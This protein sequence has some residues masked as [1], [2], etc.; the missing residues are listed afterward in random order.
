MS[1]VVAC[2][3]LCFVAALIA[4]DTPATEP[5]ISARISSCPPVAFLKREAHARK[6]TNA[7]MLGQ[8]TKAGSAICIYDPAHPGREAQTIFDTQKGFIFDMS[9]SYDGRMLLF[10]LMDSTR[11]DADGKGSFHIWEIDI[12]GSG[13]RQLTSGPYHDASAAYLPDG[14][15]VFC[16]TRV[17]SFSL[18]QDFLAAAMYTMDGDGSNLRRLE[19]NTL[20]DVTPWVMRDGSILFTRWEYQ[21]KN[22]F[23]VQG[24]WTINPDGTRVQLFYGNTL[25]IP[26]AIYGAKQIPG[27]HKVVCVMAAHHKLP[28]GAIGII[29]RRLGLE[30]PEAMI[31]ITPEVPYQPRIGEA[32]DHKQNQSWGPGDV[33]YP[34]SYTD[35]YPIAE[36]L[37]LVS[38]GGPAE[39]GP[40]RYRLFLLDANGAKALLYEDKRTS[41][42]NPVPL[43]PRAL[44]HTVPGDVPEPKGEGVFFVQDIY[45]G[46]LEGGVKRGDVK[47]IQVMSQLPKK[48]NTEGMRYQDHY[49]VMGEGTYYAKYCYGTVPVQDDGSACFKAPAGVE[50]YFQ[51]LDA[52]GREVR[53]MGTVTQITTGETQGCIGCHESRFRTPGNRRSAM[54]MLAGRTPDAITPPSWG[55]GPVD[56]VKQVQ[57]VFD[58]YC[59]ECH[60]GQTPPKG[61]DLSGDASRLFNMAFSTL[62]DKQ[63]I[64]YYYINHGPTGNF[65]PL[66]TGSRVSKLVAMIEAGHSDVDMDA[67]SRRRIYTW[68]DANA[69]YYGSSDMSRPHTMGGR[70]TWFFVKDDQRVVAQPEPWFE[71]FLVTWNRDCASCHGEFT[72]MDMRK[73]GFRKAS[74]RWINLSHP[75]Y[76]R[77]LNAHLSKA[78]GGMGLTTKKDGKTPPAFNDKDNPT[79]QAI[80]E[81]IRQGQK[82]LKARP[83]MDMA[84]GRAIPQ[85]RDFGKLY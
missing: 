44:P 84:G 19:Y 49:P 39:S 47:A 14:R 76:S 21:D 30:N 10:S 70:D 26:N 41:C 28:L 67:E 75:E 61:I 27:T 77:V 1:R 50:L 82:A 66:K 68:I 48:Y 45:E 46:L 3:L 9:P 42:F 29:D 6:G 55:A 72:N 58:R 79:Y 33:L 74:D 15:I 4:T 5:P 83:R 80:Y 52:E 18:C 7:T 81:A 62:I 59:V 2:A 63:L 32:W 37:F 78:A 22:I 8:R 24:L 71:R 65:P 16:S 35:P 56:F 64:D 40:K 51:A 57:P 36:D 25:T 31:N 17:E 85:Q 11:A 23:S 73:W 13:L 34:W 53:R 20:C 38:Y 12:D 54:D 43:A 69:P 60:S